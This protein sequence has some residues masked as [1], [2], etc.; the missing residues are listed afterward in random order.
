MLKYPSHMLHI[1]I[2][3]NMW[4]IVGLDVGKYSMEEIGF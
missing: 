1:G 3:S 2:F 4:A